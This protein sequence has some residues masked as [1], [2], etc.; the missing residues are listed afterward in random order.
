MRLTGRS[1]PSTSFFLFLII[2]SS[3][4]LF[5]ALAVIRCL[6]LFRLFQNRG[7]RGGGENS[8]QSLRQRTGRLG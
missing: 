7:R 6:C 1:T 4:A 3:A 2:R 5:S 8:G